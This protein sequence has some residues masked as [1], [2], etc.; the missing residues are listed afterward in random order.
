M[1]DIANAM[2]SVGG[3]GDMIVNVYGSDNMSVTELANAVEQKI[4]TMQK[5]RTQ[6]W[7]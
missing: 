7:A 5:R 2:A 1:K 4:I 3:G 6:A